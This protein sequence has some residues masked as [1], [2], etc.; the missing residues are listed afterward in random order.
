[1]E[2]NYKLLKAYTESVCN[3]L[4]V[5][6]KL[7]DGQ[8]VTAFCGAPNIAEQCKEG[9]VIWLKRTS[10]TSRLVK[11]NVA[12]VE[13]D[14]SLVFANP[15]Y[16]KILFTEA[17]ENDLI[18]EFDKYDEYLALET[19]GKYCGIDFELSNSKGEKCYVYATSIYSKRNADAVFPHTINFFEMKVFE[20]L[21]KRKKQ[22]HEACVFLIV[23]RN[24]CLNARFVWDISSLASGAVYNAAQNGINF[25]CYSCN[26]SK[27]LIEIDHKL[28]I[29][30]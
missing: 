4:I 9:R 23:P 26:V 1:M 21:I 6:A 8:K 18:N 24:D 29:L 7:E 14:G 30:Y 22:G 20:E 3:N 27:N 16:D 10:N 17:F 13:I 19:E 2:Y 28:D 5:D 25:I 11:Y 15:K 12:F